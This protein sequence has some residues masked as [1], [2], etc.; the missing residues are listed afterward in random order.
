MVYF[1][2]EVITVNFYLKLLHFER[3]ETN[4][5]AKNWMTKKNVTSNNVATKCEEGTPLAEN[6]KA[7]NRLLATTQPFR[8]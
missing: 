2:L 8:D 1:L 3:S 5:D 4:D 6:E 7:Q